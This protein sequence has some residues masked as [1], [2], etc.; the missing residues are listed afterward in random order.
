MSQ[1]IRSHQLEPAHDGAPPPIGWGRA[2]VLAM[3]TV[4]LLVAA[5]FYVPQ[6]I[7]TGLSGL[8]REARVW[9]ATGWTALAFVLACAAAWRFTGPSPVG[10]TH[11]VAAGSAPGEGQRTAPRRGDAATGE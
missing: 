5:F 3:G 10:R 11:D 1:A 4:V 2:L 8:S 9:L 7:L 6:F